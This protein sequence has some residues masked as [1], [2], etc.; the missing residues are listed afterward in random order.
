MEM[1]RSEVF[2][3][4]ERRA[5]E[6][7]RQVAVAELNAP[8]IAGTLS[9]GPR[10]FLAGQR[11]LLAAAS[12]SDGAMWASPIFG[13]PG[14]ASSAEGSEVAIDRTCI[15]PAP[16]DPLWANLR[17]DA[18]L[19]LLA[20]DLASRRR[21][22]INLRITEVSTNAVRG[23]VREAYQNCPKYIQR[24]RLR[25]AGAPGPVDASLRRGGALDA[26]GRELIGRSDTLFVA[27]RHPERGADSSHRGGPPG[28][29]EVLDPR[30]LRIPDYQGN[31]LFNTLGNFLVDRRAGLA[32]IDFERGRVL[33]LTGS[34]AVDFNGGEGAARSWDFTIDRWVE[35]ATPRGWSW[36]F[37][38]AS[39]FNPPPPEVERPACPLP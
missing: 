19:G 35:W 6:S 7:A 10:R 15:A 28:F 18:D 3:E 38:D 23:R 33:Q 25:I 27:S 16:G 12:D 2:H 36:E 21:L 9:P 31:G 26:A 5:Q 39:P 34:A 1:E 17:P 29:V 22:R 8:M 37:I 20:I 32:F 14:M 30:T 4:G 24:R 11:L 13:E